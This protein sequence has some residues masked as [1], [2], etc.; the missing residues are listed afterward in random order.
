MGRGYAQEQKTAI[1]KMR[2]QKKVSQT[3]NQKNIYQFLGVP[4][5]HKGICEF[6]DGDVFYG[7]MENFLMCD[8]LYSLVA[9]F[10]FVFYVVKHEQARLRRIKN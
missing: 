1:T 8:F 9:V 5:D 2:N 6:P 3:A 10:V 4:I 7:E